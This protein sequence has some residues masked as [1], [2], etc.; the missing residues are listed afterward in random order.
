MTHVLVVDDIEESRYLLKALLVGNGYRVTVAG[1]GLEALAAARR[2]PPDVIVSDVLMPNMDGFALCRAW[3]Q[4]ST[5]RAI[6]FVFYSATYTHPED[7]K[8]ALALGAVRYLIKPLESEVFLGEL[9]TVLREW[10]AR[11][12][13]GPASPL[14]EPAFRALYEAALSRKIGDKLLQ[15]ETLNRRLRESEQ[16]YRQLFDANPQP[17]WV[18][19]L[20]TLRFLAVNDAAV[21]HYGYSRDEFL[22]MTIADIRPPEDLP[23]LRQVAHVEWEGVTT[24]L[25]KHRK[26]D[27]TLIDVEITSHVLDF[28]GRRAKMVSAHDITARLQAERE[29]GA[30][31]DRYRD[32][33]EHSHDLMCTHDL[34]GK[35]LSVNAAAVR[36]TGYSHQS[37]LNMNLADLLDPAVRGDM[38][39]AYLSEIRTQG[40]ASGIMRIRTAGGEVRW[41]EYHNT[42]RTADVAVPMVR[43]MAEDITERKL[44]E[45]ALRAAEEQFRGLVE[46]SIAGIY[47]VQDDKLAYVNNRFAEILGYEPANEL[48]GRDSLSLVIENDRSRV[49]DI[50]RRRIESGVRSVSYD[51]TARR[52]DGSAVE[53]GIHSASASHRGRAAFIGLMQDISEKKRA[54]EQIRRYIAQLETA[55][56]STVTV[57]MTLS[58]MRDP[59]TA[60]HE[61]RVAEI[62]VAIGGEL[63]FDDRRLEGL[64]VAG[65]LH[66]IGK[67][68]IPA[69]ILSKPGKLTA[70][71]FQLIKGHPQSSYD[72]LKAVEFPWPVA[73]IAWQHHE[74]LDGTGYPQGLKGDAILLEAHIMAVADVVEAMAS[75]RPYRPGLGI[76]KAL[77]EIERGRGTAYDPAVA[78]ACLKL[79]REKGYA[80]PA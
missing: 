54:E 19:D 40:A 43:G 71:E 41:W 47:I 79:F 17:M 64:R 13:P 56:I 16:N 37:L 4:D 75:H 9:N 78:D 66:D 30:S 46:Q 50:M 15:L 11:P 80:I 3:M 21:T 39:A 33:V 7:E 74:R 63:G 69:E 72:V 55:F 34:E 52:K 73:E 61:R 57:A 14:D 27:G 28:Q 20:E 1:D 48:I 24:G 58:E 49:Q 59:Y 38:F 25:W 12:S 31:E 29:L 62:A 8:F 22:S 10:A 68:T 65:Y 6:P 36:F 18:Y 60:G 2:E 44:A 42:L 26:K 51:F 23:R 45:Q 5:L 76:D 35:L 70:I 32:L 67:I 77:A 53:V